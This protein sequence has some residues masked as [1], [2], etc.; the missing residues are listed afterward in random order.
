M[1]VRK[2][3]GTYYEMG[4]QVGYLMRKQNCQDF[5][6]ADIPF[7]KNPMKLDFAMKCKTAVEKHAPDLL[8]E[9]DG[10]LE[11]GGFE[12]HTLGVL[13]LSLSAQAGCTLFAISGEHT[14]DS[15]PVLARSYDFEDW[16]ISDFTGTWTSP[17]QKYASL[18]FTDIG[19]G[20]YGGANEC[21]L[22]VATTMTNPMDTAPGVLNCLASRWILDTFQTTGE[23]VDFLMEIP[24]V[25]G[26][27]FLIIDKEND[28][29]AFILEAKEIL[30][31]DKDYPYKRETADARIVAVEGLPYDGHYG[32]GGSTIGIPSA[33]IPW[34]VMQYLFE[35]YS[36]G[37]KHAAYE[38]ADFIYHEITEPVLAQKIRTEEKIP[39]EQARK[40]AHF[41]VSKQ[42]TLSRDNKYH[43]RKQSSRGCIK[44]KGSI[45]IYNWATY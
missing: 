21:G 9:L 26:V 38:L 11:G 34:D 29:L 8:Q 1:W 31:N 35:R 4:K 19:I 22:A 41:L 27:N 17:D 25:W 40:K 45:K 32:T 14:A 43:F 12:F 36:R 13:E 30:E 33:Y 39:I 28:I 24:H 42:E 23:A 2:V 44:R 37:D 3:S 16:T 20:R 6:G 5:T 18:G 15:N 10:I 7:L